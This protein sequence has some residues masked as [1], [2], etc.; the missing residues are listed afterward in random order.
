MLSKIAR[1]IY[2]ELLGVPSR[3]ET[4]ERCIKERLD[5]TD[6]LYN[7]QIE[8]AYNYL[9]SRDNLKVVKTMARESKKDI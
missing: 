8:L 5:N 7:R 9:M 2:V 1:Q 4:L 6:E 3:E